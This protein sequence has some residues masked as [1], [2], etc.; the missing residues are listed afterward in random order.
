MGI[1][2]NTTLDLSK[3]IDGSE[4]SA[5]KDTVD[6]LVSRAGFGNLQNKAG[7]VK[8]NYID[9]LK[10]TTPVDE[11]FSE[12]G[13]FAA[14]EGSDQAAINEVVVSI[15]DLYEFLD[16]LDIAVEKGVDLPSN[17]SLFRYRAEINRL[18]SPFRQ[19]FDQFSVFILNQSL[20]EMNERLLKADI[21][22]QKKLDEQRQ[23]ED[24][25]RKEAEDKEQ[26]RK[27]EQALAQETQAQEQEVAKT[28][29]KKKQEL[30]ALNTLKRELT[31]ITAF[32]KS[33]TQD[34]YPFSKQSGNEITPTNFDKI[35][36]AKG[37]YN[38][39]MDLNPQVASTMQVSSFSELIRT[40][41]KFRSEFSN[42]RHILPISNTY[43]QKSGGQLGFDFEVKVISVD[44]KIEKLI[45]SYGGKSYSY[46]HGPLEKFKAT[47][48]KES[49]SKIGFSA[50]ISENR[51]DRIE[52]DGAWGVFKLIDN[53]KLLI[54]NR[55]KSV[56][57][58]SL[59]NKDVIVEFR[60]T[61][62]NNPFYLNDIRRFSCP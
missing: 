31:P 7:Y 48:P 14:K 62:N 17:D 1:S 42:I 10:F 36:G 23:R 38:S 60:S 40:Q 28:E 39:F 53:G 44:P 2:D 49:S 46:S 50:Y 33:F 52:T 19:M 45:F 51:V 15:K 9:N 4:N 18:P 47:W 59:D 61:A 21:E 30:E 6:R 34:S 37:Q 35:F 58:Y 13:V 3:Q 41:A 57:K 12:F 24:D 25:L 29:L 16:I 55:D 8:D 5:V 20:D 32:C 27:D 22:A 43:F 56:V 26:A 54:N 11:E